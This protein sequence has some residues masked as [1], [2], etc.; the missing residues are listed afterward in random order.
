M[1]NLNVMI[2]SII[3]AEIKLAKDGRGNLSFIY[4]AI[5]NAEE[6]EL[7]E[8]LK[9]I[10]LMTKDGVFL[11]LNDGFLIII[12]DKLDI[13]KITK[14]RLVNLIQNKTE[15][16]DLNIKYYFAVSD[17][18]L[19]DDLESIKGR[20]DLVLQKTKDGEKD[21]LEDYDSEKFKA[22]QR[23]IINIFRIIFRKKELIKVSNFYKG[24]IMTHEVALE[25]VLDT[26]SIDITINKAHGAVIFIDKNTI[27]E[28]KML[29]NGVKA[30]LVGVKWGEKEATLRLDKFFPLKESPVQRK[31]IRVEP[32]GDLFVDIEFL[33]RVMRGKLLNLS[34]NG[35]AIQ[36]LYSID[37]DLT[38]QTQIEIIL[39][40]P[41][42]SVKIG[43]KILAINEK[44]KK[45]ILAIEPTRLNQ[46]QILNYIAT[47]ELELIKELRS[48]M[49]DYIRLEQY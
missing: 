27:I 17:L 18:K 1:D 26:M 22:K 34:I 35:I 46:R 28:H 29:G 33:D 5:E 42:V 41:K 7:K 12:K 31:N 13:A 15:N 4:F 21:I 32:N 37:K 19:N 49:S 43:G 39:N 3:E 40:L 20:L 48:N 14:N 38:T 9:A 44:E 25:N 24:I 36:S 23:E 10:Y 11:P 8:I 6:K 47:R 2:D 45:I 30:N 16:S